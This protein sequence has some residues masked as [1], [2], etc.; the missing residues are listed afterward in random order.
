MN[1]EIHALLTGPALGVKAGVDDQ[2]AATECDRLKVAEAADREV[3]VHTKLVDQLLRVE[4]PAFGISVERKQ[5]ADQRQLV[6]IFALPDVTGDRL[7]RGEIGQAVLAVQDR[8][9]GD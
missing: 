1:E 2:A 7:V 4:R 9:C 5:R 6:R 8:S 3:V